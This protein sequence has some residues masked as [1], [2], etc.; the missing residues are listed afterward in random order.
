MISKTLGSLAVSS[1]IALGLMAHAG[2]AQAGDVSNARL[3]C[4]VDT[5]AYD[6]LSADYCASAWTPSTANNP[7]VAYF[8]VIGLPAGSYSYTWK[9]LKT[10]QTGVCSSTN[11]WCTRSIR[12]I[13]ARDGTAEVQVIVRDNQ[14]GATKT[15]SA[16]AEFLDAWH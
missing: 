9:D 15:V 2:T 8:E 3:A 10:G 13:A 6:Q 16:L 12:I 5:Y 14:T 1:L 4:Y 11:K 7:T